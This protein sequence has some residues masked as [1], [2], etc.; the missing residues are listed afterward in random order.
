[1]RESDGAEEKR[2]SASWENQGEEGDGTLFWRIR[3]GCGVRV[4]NHGAW[5]DFHE[6]DSEKDMCI[7]R[8]REMQAGKSRRKG[9][10][11]E[12]ESERE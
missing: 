8:E 1:M 5:H 12:R 2:E 9:G 6:T 4:W 3:F 11:R 10:F 7:R